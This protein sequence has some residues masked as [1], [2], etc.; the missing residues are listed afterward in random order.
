ITDKSG[1]VKIL[2][3]Y[4]NTNNNFLEYQLFWI[5]A[6]VEDYLLGVGEYGSV[7]HKLYELSSDFK[8]ARAKVLEI[9]EQGF[10]FKE[11]RNEYLRTG[12]SD[13]LSWSSAIG[14]RN[15]KSAERNYILD[16]FSKGSPINY[17]VASCVKKL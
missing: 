1:L 17:L 12:Q 10:G 3:N 8:I 7:L 13:W 6:I 15:L 2:L 16:Y 4:L 11:I 14:T 5:G 9:P